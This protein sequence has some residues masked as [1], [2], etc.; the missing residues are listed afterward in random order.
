VVSGHTVVHSESVN[1]RITTL[2]R[3]ELSETC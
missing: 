2:P 3:N 1:A